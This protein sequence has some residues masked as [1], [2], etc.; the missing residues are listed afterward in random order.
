VWVSRLV[1]VDLHHR[2]SATWFADREAGRDLL[3]SPALMPPEVAG[4]ISRRTGDGRLARRA[5]RSILGI[6]AL[7]LV[8]LDEELALRSARLAADL[9]MRGADAVYVAVAERLGLRL[10]TLDAEQRRRAGR[11]VEVASLA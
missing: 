10:V 8:V 2:A 5:V 7:R 1:P 11:V 4:A 3:V 9:A 6:P